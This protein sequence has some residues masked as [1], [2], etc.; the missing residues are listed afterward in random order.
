M[1]A[2]ILLLSSLAL[3]L[4]A[5]YLTATQL[6][7]GAESAA[8]TTTI[9][10]SNGATGPQGPQGEQGP[11]GPRGPIG[12]TGPTGPQGPPGSGGDI[13]SGAPANFHPGFLVINHPG[14]Q[15]TIY[16]CLKD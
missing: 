5:G 14:G 10:I 4:G 7:S 13:C 2:K 8:V 15:T 1:K 6:S 12:E 3:S 11:P 9:T 16:T